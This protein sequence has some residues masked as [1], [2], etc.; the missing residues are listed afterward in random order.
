MTLRKRH[1]SDGFLLVFL[2]VCGCGL[3]FYSQPVSAAMSRALQI[4]TD[5]LLPSLYPFFVLSNLLVASGGMLSLANKGASLM[6]LLFGLPGSCLAALLLGMVGGYPTG[7]KTVA[8]LYQ[9]G[10]C[11]REDA[12]RTLRFCN[13]G[14]PAFLISALGTG[15]LSDRNLGAL[16]YGLHIISALLIGLLFTEKASIVKSSNITP[17]SPEKSPF[18]PCFLHSV[19]DAFSTFLQVCAFVLLFAVVMCLFCQLPPVAALPPLW[20]GILCGSLELTSGA[21]L[22]SQAGLSRKILCAALCF[23]CGWGGCS[24]QLQTISILRQAGLPCRDYLK[25]KLLHGGL[26]AGLALLLC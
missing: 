21:A 5:V 23:I 14:G 2:V 6:H 3:L 13:N 4:C 9:K 19:T 16:L 12:C 1:L 8:S 7:A 18:L 22:L 20:Q 26:S 24:I 25:A 10:M 11:S 17:T 15:L